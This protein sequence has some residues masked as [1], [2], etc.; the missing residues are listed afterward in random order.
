MRGIVRGLMVTA[1]LWL[2]ACTQ[3]AQTGAPD[4]TGAIA[5]TGSPSD[6]IWNELA[7]AARKEGKL[8]LAGNPSSET[9]QQLPEAFKR[10]FGVEIEYIAGRGSDLENRLLAER[11]AGVYG[12]DVVISGTNSFVRMIEHGWLEPIRSLL[13]VPEVTDPSAWRGGKL[14]YTD[15]EKRLIL[16]LASGVTGAWTINPQVV[17]E[18]ELGTFDDLLN[19]KWR[20][21]ISMEDPT[22][23]G[24]G[25][26]NAA[27]IYLRK[28][29][30]F[31]RRLYVDQ[32]P[33]FSR[34]DRQM[35]DWLA[36]GIY[37]VTNGLSPE[38]VQPLIQEGLPAKSIGLLG[39][40]GW[41]A[42]GG[43]SVGL[44]SNAPHPNAAKLFINWIASQEGQTIYS[45][46][47][48]RVARRADV[49]VPSVDPWQVP[50]EGVDYID[51]DDFVYAAEIRPP[52]I[53]RIREIVGR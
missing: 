26:G 39:E 23:T 45:M 21:K 12:V 9:R 4:S 47:E 19:P 1:F 35:A 31:F 28:G 48:T 34:D 40:T 24:Q 42:S 30:E 52:I 6:P 46:A 36:R 38:A 16:Q 33:V 5:G 32:Q 17:N 22:V 51:A 13:V 15:P 49:P 50:R 2:A 11:A 25:A 18:S 43:S 20:G 53:A 3:A 41:L 10:R 8:V 14:P 29:E 37:P 44:L 27:Y 7:E